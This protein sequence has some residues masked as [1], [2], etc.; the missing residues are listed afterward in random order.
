VHLLSSG[1]HAEHLAE[2]LT[3]QLLV[4]IAAAYDENA[5]SADEPDE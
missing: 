3:E 2:Q 1:Q 4:R 5:D